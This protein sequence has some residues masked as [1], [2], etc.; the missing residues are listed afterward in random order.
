MAGGINI[1]YMHL[2]HDQYTKVDLIVFIN[3]PKGDVIR[4][5][6]NY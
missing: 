4:D 6:M 5:K 2:F 1:V 3:A